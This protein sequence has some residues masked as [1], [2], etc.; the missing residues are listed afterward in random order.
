[1]I[2]R[3]RLTDPTN[4]RIECVPVNR[5]PLPRPATKRSTTPFSRRRPVVD[6]HAES[7]AFHVQREVFTHYGQADQSDIRFFHSFREF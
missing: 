4:S 3:G 5:F 1:M 6:R 2:R 7:F